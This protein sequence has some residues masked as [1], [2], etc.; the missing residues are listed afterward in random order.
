MT[1]LLY[2]EQASGGEGKEVSKE[3]ASILLLIRR[4]ERGMRP[5]KE[6]WTSNG[7]APAGINPGPSPRYGS[8]P[9]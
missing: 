9:S 6:S 2:Q 5:G 3:P 1:S 4:G 7:E 8:I